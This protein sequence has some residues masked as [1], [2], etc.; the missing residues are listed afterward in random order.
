MDPVMNGCVLHMITVCEKLD[1]HKGQFVLYT[2]AASVS[3]V[4]LIYM[5]MYAM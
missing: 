5:Y 1:S 3:Y 4:L 2:H